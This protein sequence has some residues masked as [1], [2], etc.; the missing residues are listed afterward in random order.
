MNHNEEVPDFLGGLGDMLPADVLK[1]VNFFNEPDEQSG[2]C[3][4]SAM[5]RKSRMKFNELLE[6]LHRKEKDHQ[7]GIV[8][9]I[10]E[11]GSLH[12]DHVDTQNFY[13]DACPKTKTLPDPPCVGREKGDIDTSA[14]PASLCT[15]QAMALW[16]KAQD[17]GYVDDNYQPLISRTQSAILAFEMAKCLGIKDKWKVFETF[18]DRRNMSRDYSDALDQKQSLD[19]RDKLKSIFS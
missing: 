18:W 1:L 12:V 7:G 11:K 4:D 17:A 19:F 2:T 15:E 6:Q 13:G 9:N 5:A 3:S 8:L 10:Y 16:K 14:L